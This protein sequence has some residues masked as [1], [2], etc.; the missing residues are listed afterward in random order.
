VKLTKKA[1][2]WLRE[3]RAEGFAV[4]FVRY[5]EDAETPGMLGCFAGITL[6][7]TKRVKVST[8]RRTPQQIE[9]ILAH[10][11][12]HVRG[13]ARGTDYPELGL[14]CGGCLSNFL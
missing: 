7:D 11:L 5:C 10:E 14:K 8:R 13:A 1:H 3:I 9:A 6:P 4:E 12:E 2:R